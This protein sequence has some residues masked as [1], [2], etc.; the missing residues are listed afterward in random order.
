AGREQARHAQARRPEDQARR[1]GG[2]AMSTTGTKTPTPADVNA[3]LARIAENTRTFNRL[4]TTDAKVAQTPKQVVWTLNKARLYHY[5]PVAPSPLPLSPAGER[6]RGEGDKR[7][8]TPLLLVFAIMNRPHVLD[9]RPGHSFV[10]YMLRHG[11][12]LY[13]LDWGAPGPED[14]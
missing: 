10:E 13:L 5:I 12:D 14:R 8:K 7:H 6:G 11:Y 3:E 2:S 4:L 1:G 9:L